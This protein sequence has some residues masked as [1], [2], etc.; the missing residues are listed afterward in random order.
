GLNDEARIRNILDRSVKGEVRE[1]Y[2]REFDNKN[3]ELQNVLDNSAIGA[4]IGAIRGANAGAITGAA[5]SFPN[6]PA[7]LAGADIIPARG[8]DENWI[9]AGGRPTNAVPV[10]VNAGGGIT[11]KDISL[12]DAENKI[13]IKSEEMQA[14][15]SK[16]K[17]E[18]QVYQIRAEELEQDLS[19]AQEELSEMESLQSRAENLEQDV[20]LAREE[21]SEM[22]SL[23]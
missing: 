11:H 18:I 16:M 8:L 12:A 23:R 2:R 9:I 7:G 13:S 22:Q 10:A 6:V 21:L 14:L 1:W 15:Q 19:L 17:E 5:N 20:S 4:N 3:W